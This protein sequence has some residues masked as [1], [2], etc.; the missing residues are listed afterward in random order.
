MVKEA[1]EDGKRNALLNNIHNVEF[2]NMKTEEWLPGF[3]EQKVN[4]PVTLIVD[5]P[6]DGMHPKATKDLL[7]FGSD[8]IIYVSC[9]PATLVRD[10]TILLEEN[11]Y[12]ITDVTPVDM[13]PHT[14]HIETVVRLEKIKK[15]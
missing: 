12:M 4:E 15:N 1:S 6:R 2:I 14:H 9:N 10:L 7:A 13:F 3:I 11:T 5:P 8:I